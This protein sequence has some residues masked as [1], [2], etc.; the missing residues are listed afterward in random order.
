[1]WIAF[2]IYNHIH[3]KKFQK[4]VKG[5]SEKACKV[6]FGHV[7]DNSCQMEE[8]SQNCLIW[9]FE[10]MPTPPSCTYSSIN[11]IHSAL[12]MCGNWVLSFLSLTS[13]FTTSCSL[14]KVKASL[15]FDAGWYW[16]NTHFIK[17][18][19]LMCCLPYLE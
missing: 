8:N 19:K 4:I 2:D 12:V 17:P 1:M 18:Y 14:Q 3:Q 10:L 15:G 7:Y 5:H 13:L 11:P 6:H 16:T 9:D